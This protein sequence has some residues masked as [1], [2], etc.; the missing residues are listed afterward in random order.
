MRCSPASAMR[1]DGDRDAEPPTAIALLVPAE[2]VGDR[3]CRERT[4]GVERGAVVALG[5][6]ADEVQA[7][8]VDQVFEAGAAAVGA[9]AMVA[10]NLDHGFDDREQAVGWNEAQGC[11]EPRVGVGAVVG[12]AEAAADG[13]VVADQGI[14]FPAGDEG[15]V[16]GQDVDRVVVGE[17]DADLEF[18]GEIDRTVEGLLLVEAGDRLLVE[19]DLVVGAAPGEQLGRKHAGVG[20]KA[21]VALVLDRSGR[22]H[23][24]A[25]DVAAGAQR[26]EQRLVDAGDRWLELALEDAVI[27]DALAGRDPQGVVGKLTGDGVEREVLGCRQRA[28]RD[29]DAR[30]ELVF[31]FQLG[32]LA[33]GRGVAV[34]LLV[35]AVEL[36]QLVGALADRDAAGGEFVGKGAAQ[37]TAFALE[38]L[39]A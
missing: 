2:E 9:A 32:L 38:G 36:E 18:A 30:H 22:G 39:D 7:A 12:H 17:G 21:G 14:A 3:K 1:P 25:D 5:L 31:L 11:R 34:E 19:E 26:R 6:G 28:A 27:L 24:V 20:A 4:R 15:E 10:L 35:A 37:A 23:Q 13:D 33:L 8:V 16:L 29:A